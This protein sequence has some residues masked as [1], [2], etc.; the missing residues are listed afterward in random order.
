MGDDLKPKKNLKDFVSPKS[1]NA[2]NVL[3]GMANPLTEIKKSQS[4]SVFRKPPNA[5]YNHLDFSALAMN[6]IEEEDRKVKT[7]RNQ[8]LASKDGQDKNQT[9]NACRTGENL[10]SAQDEKSN[11]GKSTIFGKKRDCS[12]PLPRDKR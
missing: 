4:P 10:P 2:P 9:P 11:S 12:V 1:I 7:Q 8:E 3:N 5:T 6:P